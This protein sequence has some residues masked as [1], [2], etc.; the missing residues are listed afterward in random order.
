MVVDGSRPRPRRSTAR[1][2]TRA[3]R[4]AS[5]GAGAGRRRRCAAASASAGRVPTGRPDPPPRCLGHQ[6]DDR[7]DARARGGTSVRPG[8]SPPARGRVPGGRRIRPAR[9][10]RSERRAR[11]CH[12]DRRLGRGCRGWARW[13]ARAHDGDSRPAVR[14]SVAGPIAGLRTIG[15]RNGRHPAGREPA[16][17]ALEPVDA[18]LVCADVGRSVGSPVGV[19]A[20][21]GGAVRRGVDGRHR[22]QCGGGAAG[23]AS[24]DRRAGRRSPRSAARRSSRWFPGPSPR[25]VPRESWRSPTR[26]QG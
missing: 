7:P 2:S 16:R 21:R 25:G 11:R 22:G 19:P 3:A 12:G 26:R 13:A 17:R 24:D 4:P 15:V 10:T 14:R 6:P 8:T 1:R 9:P 23:R 5:L 18:A 20:G